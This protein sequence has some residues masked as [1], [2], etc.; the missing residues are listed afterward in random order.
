MSHRHMLRLSNLS[1]A[2]GFFL[3]NV[4]ESLMLTHLTHAGD[5]IK[6]DVVW[7]NLGGT[8]RLR[9]GRTSQY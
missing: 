4:S 9:L 8:V 7:F 1:Y 5:S 3:I 6:E 2:I